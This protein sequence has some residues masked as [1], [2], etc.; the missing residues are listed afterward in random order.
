VEGVFRESGGVHSFQM[1]DQIFCLVLTSCIPEISSSFLMRNM[2][3]NGWTGVF[4]SFKDLEIN[5][6]HKEMKLI[7]SVVPKTLCVVSWCKIHKV[8]RRVFL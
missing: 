6:K 4:S 3:Q 5:R 7:R 1:V 8:I 2:P